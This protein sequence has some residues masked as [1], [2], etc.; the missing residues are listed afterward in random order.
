MLMTGCLPV[1]QGQGGA[2]A[3]EDGF[4]LG[5]ALASASPAQVS[6]RLLIYEEIRRHRASVMQILS[7]AGQDEGEKIYDAASK[8]M[9][10]DKVPSKSSL[11]PVRIWNTNSMTEKQED[12]FEFNFAYDVITDSIQKVKA[13]V[14]GYELPPGYIHQ[15]DSAQD[16][17]ETHSAFGTAA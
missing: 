10:A 14:P 15:G 11:G 13:V 4:A 7:N 3:I 12:F 16:I 6:S 5:I 9:P 8:L 2:Q 17:E 1:D